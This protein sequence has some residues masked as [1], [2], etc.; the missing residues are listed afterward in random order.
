M[1]HICSTVLFVGAAAKYYRPILQAVLCVG[2]TF[3]RCGSSHVR[4]LVE[5]GRSR[6][7]SWCCVHA[8]AW[9][10]VAET[11]SPSSASFADLSYQRHPLVCWSTSKWTSA[12]T[13]TTDNTVVVY[14]TKS[15]LPSQ[16]TLMCNTEII[17]LKTLQKF[18]RQYCSE[19]PQQFSPS[20]KHIY[21]MSC[22]RTGNIDLNRLTSTWQ[23]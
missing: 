18:E 19:T 4:S 5:C 12:Q 8:M 20:L 14:S 3:S 22:V 23:C 13:S 17:K 6:A 9:L 10:I 15:L 16:T 7:C 21:W 1:R 2:S 11:M